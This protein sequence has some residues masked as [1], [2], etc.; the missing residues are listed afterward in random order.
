MEI[1]AAAD[2]MARWPPFWMG[3]VGYLSRSPVVNSG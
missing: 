1:R 3:L 2:E